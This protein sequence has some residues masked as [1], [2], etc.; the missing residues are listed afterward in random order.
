VTITAKPSCDLNRHHVFH[1]D[2]IWFFIT[3]RQRVAE[4]SR[5][6]T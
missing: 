4:D 2:E 5:V 6:P 3:T 1:P